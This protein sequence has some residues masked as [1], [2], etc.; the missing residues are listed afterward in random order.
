MKTIF[1]RRIL[2]NFLPLFLLG[3]LALLPGTASANSGAPLIAG[4]TMRFIM[5]YFLAFMLGLAILESV[6]LRW[7]FKCNIWTSLV[8]L[9]FANAFS[10]FLG[11]I[12]PPDALLPTSGLTIYNFFWYPYVAW[13]MEYCL[14]ALFEFP[15]VALAMCFSSITDKKFQRVIKAVFLIHI[16]F[17]LL[18]APIFLYQMHH[19]SIS[20]YEKTHDLSF[21]KDSGASVYYFSPS[22]DKVL[23]SHLDGTRQEEYLKLD[24]AV[25]QNKSLLW[26]KDGATTATYDLCLIDG[27]GC[28]I[29]KQDFVRKEQWRP[30][31]HDFKYD[32]EKELLSPGK[33]IGWFLRFT[34][35]LCSDFRMPE[36][37]GRE[38]YTAS[39]W[40]L[41]SH[42]GNSIRS[43]HD[44]FNTP[45]YSW[46]LH[47]LSVLPG[48]RFI[49]ALGD[50]ICAMDYPKR[51]I[52]IIARGYRPLVV[53]DS[54]G[55]TAK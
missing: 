11:M 17:Y 28:S 21:L 4:F 54:D 46:P 41:Y 26:L 19:N 53:L 1:R 45:I 30:N 44:V 55:A 29:L 38:F 25:V 7:W 6:L 15:F 9:F 27:D 51:R 52:G 18:A 47:N 2:S 5:E 48:D 37:N 31:L 32:T 12:L 39:S 36:K 10:G 22:G 35:R 16:P 50:Q 14:S 33:N 40:Y 23:R 3:F 42:T 34:P 8:I 49:F 43:E 13:L 24:H 20:G